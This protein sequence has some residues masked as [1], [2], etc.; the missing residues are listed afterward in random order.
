M[1]SILNHLL[2][3]IYEDNMATIT[4]SN[5]ECTTKR[6][7]HIDLWH[8][9]LLDWVS[10]N[11]IILKKIPTSNNLSDSLTK[12]LGAQLYYQ[13]SD[14]LLSKYSPPYIVL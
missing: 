14:T 12:S 7:C 2:S 3:I 13:H 8:F 11:N 9:A 4:V 10:N 5:K 6:L 1:H